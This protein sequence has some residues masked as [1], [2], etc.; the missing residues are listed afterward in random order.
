MNK[1]N[2]LIDVFLAL[3]TL[4]CGFVTLINATILVVHGNLGRPMHGRRH[5]LFLLLLPMVPAYERRPA[6]SKSVFH[7][8]ERIQMSRRYPWRAQHP[9]AVICARP[10]RFANPYR[11]VRITAAYWGVADN[12]GL[13]LPDYTAG[14]IVCPSLTT[15]TGR[16]GPWLRRITREV[17]AAADRAAKLEATKMAVQ[18]FRDDLYDGRLDFMADDLRAELAGRDLGCWCKVWDETTPCPACRGGMSVCPVCE[19]TGFARWPCHCDVEMIAANPAIPFGW[20]KTPCLQPGA[21]SILGGNEGVGR[22][23]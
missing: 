3:V 21:G 7:V 23:V 8:P 4:A 11:A 6:M 22:N 14:M 20:A 9:E 16:D 18:L 12:T 5:L 10:Y 2:P 15:T 19:G 1:P 13:V 17:I